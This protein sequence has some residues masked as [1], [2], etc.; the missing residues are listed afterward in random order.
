MEQKADKEVQD[1]TD[2]ENEER[3]I[4]ET[5]HIHREKK[6]KYNFGN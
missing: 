4:E 5:Y 1:I 3:E 2:M 6:K